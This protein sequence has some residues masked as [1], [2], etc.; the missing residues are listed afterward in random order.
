MVAV[1]VSPPFLHSLIFYHIE[2]TAMHIKFI[3]HFKRAND[4]AASLVSTT[5]TASCLLFFHFRSR[6]LF[7]TY[8]TFLALD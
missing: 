5:T 3:Y 2:A 7:E 8:C 6:K 4:K 1:A